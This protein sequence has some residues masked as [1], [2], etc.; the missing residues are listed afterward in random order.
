MRP[1]PFTGD[2]NCVIVDID[3]TLADCDHRRIHI[4]SKPKNWKAFNELME[5]DTPVASIDRLVRLFNS[6]GYKIILCS[7]R[8]AAFRSV[9]ETWLAKWGV[10]YERLYMR[11]EKDYRGDDLVKGE[12]LDQIMADGWRPWLAIDDRNRVVDMWRARG[13]LCLQCA[14]GDF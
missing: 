4:I 2:Y 1:V 8:E 11:A 9:T 12:L 6:S 3:G 13:L 10:P 14:P 7:G 5:H